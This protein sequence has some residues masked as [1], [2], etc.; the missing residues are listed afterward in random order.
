MGSRQARS[1]RKVVCCGEGCESEASEVRRLNE[2]VDG[3]GDGLGKIVWACAWGIDFR[4]RRKYSDQKVV[5]ED[6]LDGLLD[7]CVTLKTEVAS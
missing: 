2:Y 1:A 3:D 7:A 4:P 5:E 6:G